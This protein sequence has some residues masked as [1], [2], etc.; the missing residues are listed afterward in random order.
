MGSCLLSGRLLVAHIKLDEIYKPG[1]KK[2]ERMCHLVGWLVGWGV[3]DIFPIVGMGMA[4][5][6]RNDSEGELLWHF[7][8]RKVCRFEGQHLRFAR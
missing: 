5:V 4:F 6:E 2:N 7:G 1:R 8:S 3:S